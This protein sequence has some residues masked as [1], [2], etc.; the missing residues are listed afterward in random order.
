MAKADLTAQRLRE[1]LHY[2]PETGVFTWAADSGRWGRIKAGTAAGCINSLGYVVIMIDRRLYYAHRLAW[3]WARGVWPAELIDH[4][5]GVRHDNFLG[6]LRDASH[7]LNRQN[8]RQAQSHNKAGF[9]GVSWHKQTKKYCAGIWINGKK[10]HLGLFATAELA[11]AAYVS[12][13]RLIHPGN[14]L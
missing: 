6:N 8:Q 1:L 3:L 5:N 14:T 12:A 11:H 7:S 10:R 2:D 4:I 9:L 13:K